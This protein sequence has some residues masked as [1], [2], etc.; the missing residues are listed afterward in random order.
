[1]E[2]R[3]G[4]AHKYND[5]RLI[6]VKRRIVHKKY[7]FGES[8]YDFG[9]LQLENKL[10]FSESVHSIKLPDFGDAHIETGA[11]CLVSGWGRTH[12]TSE[13]DYLLRGVEVPI[14]D[15]KMCNRAYGGKITPRMICAG[16]EKGGKDCKCNSKANYVPTN[17]FDS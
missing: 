1:M 16:Y 12:N 6:N 8:D 5:G 2:I 10:E 7:T 14:A 11:V 15:Q 9:L 4:A 17:I 13:T 3:I